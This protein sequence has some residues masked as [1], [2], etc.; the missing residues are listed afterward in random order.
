MNLHALIN[1]LRTHPWGADAEASAF[2]PPAPTMLAPYEAQMLRWLAAHAY[3]GRGD[4]GDLGC[5]LGGSTCCFGHGLT[6]NVQAQRA[7][8]AQLHVYDMFIAPNDDYSRSLIGAHKKPGDSVLDTF[9]HHTAPYR[10]FMSVHQGD[11]LSH[12]Y[13]GRPV[14]ILFVDIAK[15][16]DLNDH[17]VSQF[18]ANTIGAGT[19]VVH[20]DYN[21]PWLPWVH[22]TAHL[23]RPVSAYIADVAGS[24]LVVLTD[25]PSTQAI[26][27]CLYAST[28]REEKVAILERERDMN[29]NAYS[30]GLVQLSS[31]WLAFLEFGHDAFEARLAHPLLAHE[32]I[33]P[34]VTQMRASAAGMKSVEGYDRYHRAYFAAKAD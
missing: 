27:T 22:I 5:F 17:V 1:R 10:Q 33:A 31:A 34:Q 3:T 2:A 12:E 7:D 15:K 11:L 13:S 16:H 20:Q 29:E 14:E 9:H 32:D 24:R 8:H 4:I 28:T 21:H 26:D 23:P 6:A 30:A 25:H 18:F 19:L